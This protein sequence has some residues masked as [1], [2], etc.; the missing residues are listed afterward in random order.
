VSEQAAPCVL[1]FE[2]EEALSQLAQGGWSVA[3]TLQVGAGSEPSAKSGEQAHTRL[4][5][6]RQRVVGE[7][8]LELLTAPA[9]PDPEQNER[10]R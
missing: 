6:V 10:Q 2:L 8:A 9:P 3:R 4:V 1:A 7:R 5:V